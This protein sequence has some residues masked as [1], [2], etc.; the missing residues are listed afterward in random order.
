MRSARSRTSG[1][2]ICGTRVH[3]THLHPDPV[4]HGTH[5]PIVSED[6]FYFIHQVDGPIGN[7]VSAVDFDLDV[8]LSYLSLALSP[9]G[10]R[11]FLASR[12][13]PWNH[14]YPGIAR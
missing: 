7:G 12:F 13:T 9:D 6:F 3:T 4:I 11:L 10:A 5:G 8:E 2:A 14:A 1:S